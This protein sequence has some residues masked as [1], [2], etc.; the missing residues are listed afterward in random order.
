[1][2]KL[3][4]NGNYN[5]YDQVFQEWL[6]EGIIEKVNDS[7]ISTSVHYLPHRH[8]VKLSSTTTKLR[9]VFDASAGEK[10][11]PSLNQLRKRY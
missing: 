2:N 1:M 4:K 9:P 7:E 8:V 11:S 3:E 6:K 10:D 5:E